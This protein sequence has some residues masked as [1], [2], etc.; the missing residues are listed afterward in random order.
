VTK[1]Q[2]GP[3]T[4]GVVQISGDMIGSTVIIIDN[5][6]RR[7]ASGICPVSVSSVLTVLDQLE[8]DTRIRVLDFLDREFGTR[9]VKDLGEQQLTRA[10][11]YVAAILKNNENRQARKASNDT[12]R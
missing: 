3:R 4:R 6:G 9:M 5:S 10:M 7:S 11:L 12:N 1:Q 2:T 8:R